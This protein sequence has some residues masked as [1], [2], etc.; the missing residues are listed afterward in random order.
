VTGEHDGSNHEPVRIVQ[1]RAQ[2]RRGEI[3]AGNRADLIGNLQPLAPAGTL[4]SQKTQ[5]PEG[6]HLADVPP[7]TAVNG[8]AGLEKTGRPKGRGLTRGRGGIFSRTAPQA[9]EAGIAEWTPAFLA[10]QQLADP[11]IGPAFVWLEDGGVRPSW[12]LIKS[13]SPALRALWQQYES[14]VIR[15]RVICRIF[16]NFDG[17]VAYYQLVLPSSLKVP[18]LEA[19]HADT[20]GHLKFAKCVEHVQ[21]RA[22]WFTWRRD[23]KLFIQCCKVCCGYHRGSAPKQGHLQPMV[24]GGVAERWAIDLTGPH[25][26][27]NGYKYIFTAIDPFSKYAVVVPIRNKEATTVAKVIVDH[28][29]LKWGLCFE[30]LSDQ[31]LEFEASLTRELLQNLGIAKIRTSGYMPSVNGAIEVHHKVLN[32]MLAKVISETQRDWSVWLNYVTFCYNSAP[33]SATGFTPHFIM[34]GQEPRWNIDFVLSNIEQTV[35]TVPEYTASV[36]D[37]LNRAFVLVREHL[38]QS[39]ETARTWYNRKVN[40]QIF[41]EGDRVRVYNPRRYKGRSPKWQSFY[42]DEAVVTLRLNDVSYVVNSP[43]WRQPK[44]VHVNKLKKIIDFV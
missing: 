26:V 36:L 37:R 22:W 1:T 21:R 12:D 18:F 27:S 3:Q 35:T 23:L 30:I 32:S 43:K 14:L 16:H 39:A 40:H 10:Q 17:S 11:D 2:R 25:P 29:F 24:M 6:A 20:V 15:N 34:T 33:H 42:K 44:V 13:S 19:V 28:L 9:V 38:Q 4:G 8:L 41:C 7:P 5:R 31:G